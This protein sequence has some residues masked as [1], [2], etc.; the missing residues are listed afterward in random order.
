MDRLH[1][2]KVFV[3]VAET[4]GFAEAARQMRMSPAGVTR[5]VAQLESGINTRLL[6]R[7]TRSVKLSEAGTRYYED[8]KRILA[9]IEDAE[10]SA[11][12]AYAMPT[13]TLCISA[14]V[15]FGRLHVLP[16]I[17]TYLDQNPDITV[18][19]LCV[20]RLVN[21]VDEGIDV[22]IRIGHLPDSGLH[23][24]NV[25][26]ARRVVCATPDYLATHGTPQTPADLAQHQLIATM[27]NW[28]SQEWHFGQHRERSISIHPR[29][30]CNN[31]EAAIA[32]ATAGWGMTRVLSYQVNHAVAAGELQIVLADYE[33]PPL[34]IHILYAEG[35]GTSAK[36]RRFVEL[37]V[38][39]LRGSGALFA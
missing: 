1:A 37:A 16:I 23:A 2:M 18:Q 22:A 39:V 24:I 17:T 6:I 36:V 30:L 21:L 7:T 4:Q 38:E 9:D 8:C 15:L 26:H 11:A 31:N 35:R 33:E 27:G 14:P 28:S 3:R 19:A 20:D 34:P 13:G 5:A 29:L 32:A 25:G 10:A 12:G